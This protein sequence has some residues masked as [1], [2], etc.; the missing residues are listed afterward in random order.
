MEETVPALVVT[1]APSIMT[2]T[3]SRANTMYVHNSLYAI[4]QLYLRHRVTVYCA[5][6]EDKLH[7]YEIKSRRCKNHC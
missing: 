7:I 1:S 6:S 3:N 4:S 5:Q 2:Q